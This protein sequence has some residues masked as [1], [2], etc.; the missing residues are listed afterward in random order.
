MKRP[1][2]ACLL[3][4]C[5]V[6]LVCAGLLGPAQAHPRHSSLADAAYNAKTRSLEVVLRVEANDLE[7][8][9]QAR[10]GV[11]R[12]LELAEAQVIAWLKDGLVLRRPDGKPAP[13]KWVGM[14]VQGASAELF[15]EFDLPAGPLGVTVEHRLFF[16]EAAQQIN[17]LNV[18]AEG[19]QT[20]LLFT[21]AS[22]RAKI[23]KRA[24]A[25][26]P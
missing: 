12:P 9:V 6:G 10:G 23:E 3:G 15:F 2:L 5:L 11:K 20:T 25:Q 22:P 24:A 26:R 19:L 16:R 7:E 14:Q 21:A 1:N 17:Q 4:A 8:A 18:S 13:L